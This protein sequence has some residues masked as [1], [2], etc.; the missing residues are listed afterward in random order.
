[1]IKEGFSNI[2]NKI[3]VM[4]NKGGV[5]KSTVSANIAT[6]LAQKG[7]K[8]GLLD[9]DIHGPSQA[10]IFGMNKQKLEMKNNK[11]Y[12]FQVNENL[13]LITMAGFLENEGQALI[14][15]GPRKYGVIKQFVEDVEWGALDYMVIDSPPGTG[16][17]PLAIA[18]LV[19]DLDGLILV[20]TAQDLSVLDSKKVINFANEVN[21]KILGLVENMSFITCS[22]CGKE[23][24]LFKSSHQKGLIDDMQMN[25]LGSLPFDHDLLVHPND[26]ES[27][28]GKYKNSKTNKLFE[29]IVSKIEDKLK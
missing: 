8:V 20:T 6:V 27:F 26:G 22:H 1:M 4:S 23:S 5:G 14:W 15:R 24:S 16:D 2:K 29:E 11:I 9:I 12:P 13:K 3:M 17:E 18:Q 7:Y 25:L 28:F 21:V 10:K 19:T